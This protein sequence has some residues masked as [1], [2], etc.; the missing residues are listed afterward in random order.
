MSPS[1]CGFGPRLRGLNGRPG[2]AFDPVQEALAAERPA[3][4]LGGAQ[5][6]ERLGPE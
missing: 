1:A 3:D 2:D 6:S 4:G 5:A